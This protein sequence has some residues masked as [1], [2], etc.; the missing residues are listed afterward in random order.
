[1]LIKG[2]Q[3]DSLLDYPGK[4]SEVV[5]LYGCNFKCHNCHNPGLVIKQDSDSISQEQLMDYLKK[6]KN[7]ELSPDGVCITGGEPT[8]NEDLPEFISKIKGLGYLIKL[9]TNGT[10]PK[11]I[12]QLLENKLLDYVAMDI[13]APFGRYEE[14]VNAKVNLEDIKESINLVKSMKDYEFRTT[15]I[16]D[17]TKE[18]IVKIADTIKGARAY[19]LQQFN[20][21]KCLDKEYEEKKPYPKEKLEEIQEEIRHNFGICEVRGI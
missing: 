8:I 17:L 11:M 7:Q 20:A 4:I 14:V 13:K 19:Y 12:K 16:P 6:R 2:I 21:K 1:M 9:D 15:V 10:N 3:E 18:D 5:F